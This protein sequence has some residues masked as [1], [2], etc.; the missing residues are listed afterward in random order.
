ML[1]VYELVMAMILRDG[2]LDWKIPREFLTCSGE[3][4]RSNRKFIYFRFL[5]WFICVHTNRANPSRDC[6][7][8]NQIP[9]GTCRVFN[10]SR[11]V[12]FDILVSF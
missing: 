12:K 5:I 10:E 7:L 6:R 1:M 8:T 4:L 3:G 2:F 11:Q 9:K